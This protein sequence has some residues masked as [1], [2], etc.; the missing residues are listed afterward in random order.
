MPDVARASAVSPAAAVGA[1]RLRAAAA[2]FT[3]A[4][5]L[6]NSDHL[7]RGGDAVS[8][9]VF[10]IGTLALV[11]EVGVV[12]LVFARHPRAPLAA[13]V[14]CFGLAAGYVLV[15]FSPD[16]SWLSDSL[17]SDGVRA[18]SAFAAGLETVGA[19]V[20]GLAGV[21]SLS[22]PT[23]GQADWAGALRHPVVLASAVGNAVILVGSFATR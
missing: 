22:E 14:I 23:G 15:H 17:V 12:A 3:V 1:D 19:V 20:L 11:L 6:H 5:L 10:W 18:V 4:V 8:A 9:D 13:A 2:F 16:R 7:R 21:G